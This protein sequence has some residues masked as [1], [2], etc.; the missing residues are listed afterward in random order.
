LVRGIFENAAALDLPFPCYNNLP[1][2]E[3][4]EKILA[5]RYILCRPGYSTIMDLKVLKSD[6]IPIFVP[7]PGQTE[8]EYLFS[9]L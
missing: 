2:A 4:A 3:L 1:T 5:S 9:I 6:A 8:Q 7:T